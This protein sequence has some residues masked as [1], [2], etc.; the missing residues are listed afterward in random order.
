MPTL[1]AKTTFAISLEESRYTLNGALLVLKPD[2]LAMV[3]TDGHRLAMVEKDHK[4]EGFNNET[5]VL[6]PQESHDRSPAP[7]RQIRR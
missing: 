3:A 6:D 7:R 1:I 4:F 5:R 2:S